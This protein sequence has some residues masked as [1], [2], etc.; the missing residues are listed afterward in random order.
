MLT[1]QAFPFG[2]DTFLKILLKLDQLTASFRVGFDQL[3]AGCDHLLCLALQGSLELVI[4]LTAAK[5]GR[6]YG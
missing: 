5:Q 3:S 4:F 2:L 6:Q 1:V